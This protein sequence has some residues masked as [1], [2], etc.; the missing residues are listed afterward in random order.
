MDSSHLDQLDAE[1]SQVPLFSLEGQCVL[2]R[3]HRVYDGD[4]CR[5][6]FRLHDQVVAFSARIKGIDTAEMRARDAT[7]R[8]L[9]IL[10]RDR[11]REL[12]VGNLVIATFGRFDKYGR[13]LAT[14]DLVRAENGG[15]TNV[16]DIL[17]SE[18]LAMEYNGGKREA[19]PALW[20]ALADENTS[21]REAKAAA[22]ESD[23]DTEATSAESDPEFVPDSD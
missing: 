20:Q 7:Q 10:A 12:L 13:V 17:I 5:L 15:M 22:R 1:C 16:A 3:P 8:A 2:A 18:R 11:M 23:P 19:D 14:L 6:A 21:L 4:S 9:A